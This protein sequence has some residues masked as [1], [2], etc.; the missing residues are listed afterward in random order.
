[1][2]AASIF[3]GCAGWNVPRADQ[4]SFSEVGSHLQRYASRFNAVE[5]N[6][7]FYRPHRPITYARWAASVPLPF[8]FAVKLP[9]AIT[10]EQRLI[11][12]REPL[13]AFFSGAT[14]LGDRLGCVLVQ[15]PPSLQFEHETAREFFAEL[16]NQTLVPVA[17]EP[18]HASWFTPQAVRLLTEFGVAGVAADPPPASLAA[19]PYGCEQIAYFRLHGS[20]RMYYS[21]YPAAYLDELARR[22]TCASEMGRQVWCIFDNT[23]LGSAT[24]NALA[25]LRRLTTHEALTD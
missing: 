5:I 17:C 12:P 7:S 10:H 1:M 16:R 14:Q 21:D 13:K 6:S 25:L 3:V 2:S 15:L 24:P 11:D 4:S 19:Q 18:R 22:I 9:K 23:A 8:R 20:P